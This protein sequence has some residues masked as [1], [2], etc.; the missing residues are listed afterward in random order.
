MHFAMTFL[1]FLCYGLRV[2]DLE[3]YKAV[4]DVVNVVHVLLTIWYWPASLFL[5]VNIAMVDAK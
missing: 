4:T 5:L 3:L 2:F 1:R